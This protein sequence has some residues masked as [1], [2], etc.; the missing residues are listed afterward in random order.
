MNASEV[1]QASSDVSKTMIDAAAEL[2]SKAQEGAGAALAGARAT[3][4]EVGTRL[5]GIASAGAEGAAESVKMLQELSDPRLK[6]LMAFSLGVGAGLWMAGAPRLITLA[7]L[8]PALVAGI[9]IA[10]RNQGRAH[11]R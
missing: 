5:P 2:A 11:R 6:L 9:A 1:R 4:D 3:A 7:A 8:S 10:S